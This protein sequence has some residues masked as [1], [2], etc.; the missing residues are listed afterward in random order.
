[1]GLMDDTPLI[2]QANRNYQVKLRFK[3]DG[4]NDPFSKSWKSIQQIEID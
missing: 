4:V 2:I 3:A 1:M